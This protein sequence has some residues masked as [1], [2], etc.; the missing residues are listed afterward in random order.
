MPSLIDELVLQGGVKNENYLTLVEIFDIEL[1]TPTYGASMSERR[2]INI[3]GQC[4][5]PRTNW[6]QSRKFETLL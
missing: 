4:E 3:L 6:L 1:G 2:L 5:R